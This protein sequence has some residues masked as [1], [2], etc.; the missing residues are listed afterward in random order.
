M[1][2]FFL[3]IAFL[4]VFAVLALVAFSIFEV[5]PWG[6]H[7]DRYRDTTGHRR[8]ESPWLD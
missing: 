3:V 6:R 2:A 4:F 7:E 5:T 1:N 8:F